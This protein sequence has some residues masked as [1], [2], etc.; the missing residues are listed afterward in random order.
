MTGT[1]ERKSRRLERGRLKTNCCGKA[2]K[3][4]LIQTRIPEDK[5]NL[6]DNNI[7]L[8]IR[9]S[10]CASMITKPG[11]SVRS[12]SRRGDIIIKI[13]AIPRDRNFIASALRL[14]VKNCAILNDQNG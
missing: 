14:K 1:A 8:I 5:A 3:A 10:G 9:I 4:E 13:I 7:Y 11:K 12:S 2:K 6:W